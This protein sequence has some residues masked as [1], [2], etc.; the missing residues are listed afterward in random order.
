M[1]NIILPPRNCIYEV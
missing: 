1:K